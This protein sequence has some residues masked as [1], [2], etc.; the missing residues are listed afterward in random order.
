MSYLFHC[1]ACISG[2]LGGLGII[3]QCPFMRSSS[4]VAVMQWAKKLTESSLAIIDQT[5]DSGSKNNVSVILPHSFVQSTMFKNHAW[6]FREFEIVQ[7]IKRWKAA[8]FTFPPRPSK[9][10]CSQSRCTECTWTRFFFLSLQKYHDLIYL[11]SSSYFKIKPL[12]AAALYLWPIQAHFSSSLRKS[13]EESCKTNLHETKKCIVLCT[14]FYNWLIVTKCTL[15]HLKK[16]WLHPPLFVA[17]KTP[18]PEYIPI[19]TPGQVDSHG[20]WES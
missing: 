7:E 8:S 9:A 10:C 19:S 13:W 20:P 15:Q 14:P 4:E 6:F 3:E 18:K 12:V 16:S 5:C 17:L 1:R 11:R 2:G